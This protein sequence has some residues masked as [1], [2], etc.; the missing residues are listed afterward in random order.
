MEVCWRGSREQIKL[1]ME[2]GVESWNAWREK[3]PEVT[4]EL[5]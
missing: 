4:P 5:E 3:N 2:E 1:I